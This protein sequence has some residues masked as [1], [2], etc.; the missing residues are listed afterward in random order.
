MKVLSLFDG[1]SCGLLALKDAGINV[2]QYVSYEID[3]NALKISK[4]HFSDFIEY[5]GDVTH[6]NFN[7]YR[8]FDLVIG[9]SPCQDLS[10]QGSKKGLDGEKSS[11]F[12]Y[13]LKAV[14]VIK[15]TYFLFENVA[16][17]SK[18]NKDRI[19]RLLNCKPVMIDSADFSAQ[20]R[21]RLYWTNINIP[22]IKSTSYDRVIDI[23]DLDIRENCQE[24]VNKYLGDEYIGRKIQKNVKNGIT[25]LLDKTKTVTCSS[26]T[27]GAN[28]N[29]IF[30]ID[31]V[32]YQPT[33]TEFERLQTIPD[34]YTQVK[35]VTYKNSVKAIGNA[36]TVNVIAH[37]FRGLPND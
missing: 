21:K 1:I 26:G 18:E 28:N 15:P 8:G 16:S 7:E 37:I 4:E 36:W 13:Y 22:E 3:K 5:K 35:G 17:M 25:F 20:R 2:R 11:L 24:I 31:G 30:N 6:A 12:F 10:Q 32:F 23:L 33:L 9:G 29:I 34:G 27:I 19:T 14:E